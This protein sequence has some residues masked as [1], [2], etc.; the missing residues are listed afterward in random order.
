MTRMW[1]QSLASL[2]VIVP[3]LS[4]SPP[5]KIPSNIVENQVTKLTIQLHWLSSLD[6]AKQQAQK[7]KKLIFWLH[8]LGDLEGTC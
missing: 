4:A 6:E 5:P 1:L 8:A 7:E 2:L 3:A